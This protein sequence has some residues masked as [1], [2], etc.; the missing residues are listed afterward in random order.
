MLAERADMSEVYFRKQFS[1]LYGTAPVQYIKRLRLNKAVELLVSNMYPVH[2]VA[3]MVGYAS[4]YYFCRE[5][6]RV[7]GLSPKQYKKEKADSEAGNQVID[8]SARADRSGGER[9]DGQ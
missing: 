4:E 6:K 7:T 1:R 2:E 3:H 8:L 9:T 5:F